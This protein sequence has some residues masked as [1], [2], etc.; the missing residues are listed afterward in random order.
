MVNN[1]EVSILVD[2]GSSTS[3]INGKLVTALT[4]VRALDRVVRVK[5]ANGT[6]LQCKEEVVACPWQCQG[7]KF[8]TTFKILPLG[9]FDIILGMD[10]LEKHNPVI[11]WVSKQMKLMLEGQLVCLQGQNLPLNSCATISALQLDQ[12]MLAGE[13]EHVVFLCSASKTTD[14]AAEPDTTI[15]VEVQSLVENSMIS[16]LSQQASPLNARVI[17]V[18]LSFKGHNPSVFDHIDMHLIKKMRSRNKLM[19]CCRV[20]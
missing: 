8:S 13:V 2:S 17:I 14:S 15:P 1:R 7:N 6:E 5:I 10:W 9:G 11:D 3:F 19:K 16:S 4:D 18:S 20:A 12:M